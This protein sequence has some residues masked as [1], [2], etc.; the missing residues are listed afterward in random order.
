MFANDIGMSQIEEIDI[1]HEGGNYGWMRREGPF[2]NGIQAAGGI[3]G[4]VLPLPANV[5]DGS[6]KDGF[7]YPVAMYDHGEG[8][9][10]TA[11]FVYTGRIQALRGKYVFGDI[12]RGR[13]FAADVAA[14]KA[15]DDGIP[16]TVAPVEEIQLFVRQPDGSTRD[17]A[18]KEL[19]EAAMGGPLPRAD[20]HIGIARD[21]ELFL[22]S[23]QDGMIRMLVE[24]NGTRTAGR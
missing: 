6:V 5:L 4:R 20:L 8:V 19:A 9:A 2:E 12:N 3:L 14:L 16:A 1:V 15:A 18:F 13:V 7:L 17:V 21:G 24:S 10:I 11:G 23:R 22:T